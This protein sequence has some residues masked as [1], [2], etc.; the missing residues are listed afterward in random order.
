[1]SAKRDILV[2]LESLKKIIY[3][4]RW[5]HEE[6]EPGPDRSKVKSRDT[7]ARLEA[8]KKEQAIQLQWPEDEEI[9]EPQEKS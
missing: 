5:A 3:R 6:P 8:L 7:M 9:Y 1:M 4:V 2:R